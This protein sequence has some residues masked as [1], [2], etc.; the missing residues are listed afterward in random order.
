[1]EPINVAE[2]GLANI[3]KLINQSLKGHHFLF[4]HKKV[5]KIMS[6]PTEKINFFNKDNMCR[7]QSLL[8]ELVSKKSIYQK[9]SYLNSL[10]SG[11]FEIL[12]RIYFHILESTMLA[13]IR[14]TH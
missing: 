1:M 2:K 9:Q 14:S 13:S 10:D 4:D 3:E 12:V 6:T 11:N 7:M 8:S 5:A